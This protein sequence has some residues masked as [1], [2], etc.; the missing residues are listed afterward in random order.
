MTG[1]VT[2]HVPPQRLVDLVNPVVRFALESPLHTVLDSALLTLHVT[3]RATGRHYDIPVGFVEVDGRLIVVTQHSWRAN[4]R[5]GREV[6]VTRRGRRVRMHAVLDEQPAS[7][8]ADLHAVIERIGPRAS[9]AQLGLTVAG[10]ATPSVAELE[11]AVCEYGLAT[12]TLDDRRGRNG[13]EQP[14]GR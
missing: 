7:V 1:T 3:G 4:L 11:A 5:G 2:H 13:G 6:E 9:R 12:I 14:R 8:A 10:D